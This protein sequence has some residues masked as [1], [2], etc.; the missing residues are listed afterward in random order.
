MSNANADLFNEENIVFFKLYFLNLDLKINGVNYFT[1]KAEIIREFLRSR[2]IIVNIDSISFDYTSNELAVIFDENSRRYIRNEEK[3]FIFI[4][5]KYVINRIDYKD[6]KTK[7]FNFEDKISE[8]N[9]S[10][11]T[12]SS[13]NITSFKNRYSRSLSR[14]RDSENSSVNKNQS[15]IPRPSRTDTKNRFELTRTTVC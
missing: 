5:N 3:I 6:V 8:I 9:S 10:P 2:K 14:F 15:K 12:D 13:E 4:P 7:K 1:L 11:K